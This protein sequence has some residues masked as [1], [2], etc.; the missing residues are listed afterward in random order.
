MTHFRSRMT[1]KWSVR[2]NLLLTSAVAA[3]REEWFVITRL[4]RNHQFNQDKLGQ[5]FFFTPEVYIM[6]II[7]L[8]VVNMQK[9]EKQFRKISTFR[10]QT[11]T[12]EG[13]PSLLSLKTD[14]QN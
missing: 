4:L 8:T 6:L 13:S 2:D 11:Y 7:F 5:P 14:I 3:H 1:S 10:D 9:C 12:P